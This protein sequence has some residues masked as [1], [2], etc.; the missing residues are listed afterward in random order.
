[1]MHRGRR[2]LWAVA[3]LLGLA[4]PAWAETVYVTD[5]LKLSLRA[6]PGNEQKSIAVVESGQ[7]LELLKAGETWSQVQLPNGTQGYLFTRY[8]TQQPPARHRFDQLT[9][10]NKNLTAQASGLQEEN[11]RLK[12]EIGKLA[13][14]AADHQKETDAVRRDYEAFKAQAAD[15]AGLKGRYD[16]AVA[17]LDQKNKEIAVLNQESTIFRDVDRYWFLAGAG[18]LLAG[19]LIGFSLK[20]Q[21]RWSSL[22]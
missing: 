13:A 6:E 7:Q 3:C 18:V 8:L 1:M 9:E 22:N 2:I 15:V 4:G 5:I 17:E 12:A 14:A 19:L 11:N 21:R 16:A 10:K 20:R